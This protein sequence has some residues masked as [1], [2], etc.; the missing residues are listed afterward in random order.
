MQLCAAY[1]NVFSKTLN[2]EVGVGYMLVYR[3]HDAVHQLVVVALHLYLFNLVLLFLGARIFS[4]QPSYV[5]DKIV[6]KYVQLRHVERLCQEGVCAF[7]EAF[8]PVGNVRF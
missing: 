6:C 5:A 1:A 7:L 2:V 3:L 8:E 4:A